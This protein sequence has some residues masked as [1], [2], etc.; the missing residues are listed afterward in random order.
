MIM[1]LNTLVLWSLAAIFPFLNLKRNVSS[2][3]TILLFCGGC[4]TLSVVLKDTFRPAV[5]S[6]F[7][8]N[9]ALNTFLLYLE[10]N[11]SAFSHYFIP[12]LLLLFSL[13]YSGLYETRLSGIKKI[14]SAAFIILLIPIVGMYIFFP[15]YP[16]FLPKNNILI[17]WAMPYILLAV[18]L[19]IYSYLNENNRI[20]KIQKLAICILIIP[21]TLFTSFTNALL[22]L[23]NIEGL[24]RYDY[25][26][27]ISSLCAFISITYIHR[28]SLL[29]PK[30]G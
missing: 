27:I 21:E 23:N 29:K 17:I 10:D 6:Y 28:Y 25:I 18:T 14:K 12:Y 19:L 3:G 4:G 8:G 26:I 20:L 11:I 16:N 24:W 1:I 2:L 22:P 15:V 9:E 30:K 7:N 5:D 13:E